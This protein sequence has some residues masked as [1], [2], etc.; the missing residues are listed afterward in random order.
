MKMNK[1][2]LIRVELA[3]KLRGVS[4]GVQDNRN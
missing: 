2:T 3:Q 1:P 4:Y